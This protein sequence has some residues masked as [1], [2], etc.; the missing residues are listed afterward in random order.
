MYAGHLDLSFPDSRENGTYLGEWVNKVSR[1]LKKQREE[2]RKVWW[3]WVG[4]REH[5]SKQVEG[6]YPR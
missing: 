6:R 1:K 4:S 3:E 5:H 2:A